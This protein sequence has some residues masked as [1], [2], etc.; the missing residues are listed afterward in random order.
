MYEHSE[1]MPDRHSYRHPK[2][3]EPDRNRGPRMIQVAALV[4]CLVS[5][6]VS[7][8]A[9]KQEPDDAAKGK[10]A[11][12]E[13]SKIFEKP[14]YTAADLTKAEVL[15]REKVPNAEFPGIVDMLKEA[16]SKASASKATDKLDQLDILI[17]LQD[18]VRRIAKT[19]PAPPDL[20]KEVTVKNLSDKRKLYITY[21]NPPK[22]PPS[23]VPPKGELRLAPALAATLQVLQVLQVDNK[24]T[25]KW[26]Q[27]KG[28][29]KP[30]GTLTCNFAE[31]RWNATFAEAPPPA[32]VTIKNAD[33]KRK[34]YIA[35]GDRD[36][37]IEVPPNGES[38]VPADQVDTLHVYNKPEWQ[39]Y[40]GV[41]K[42]ASTLTYAF[43]ENRWK[44]ETPVEPSTPEPVPAKF[45]IRNADKKESLKI[46]FDDHVHTI[47]SGEALSV[48]VSDFV[49]ASVKNG[50]KDEPLPATL[51]IKAGGE[52]AFTFADNRWTPKFSDAPAPAGVTPE[53]T[54]EV[55]LRN[56]DTTQVLKIYFGKS[57]TPLEIPPTKEKRIPLA[58]LDPLLIADGNKKIPVTEKPRADAVISFTFANNVW[59]PKI[60]PSGHTMRTNGSETPSPSYVAETAVLARAWLVALVTAMQEP[61]GEQAPQIPMPPI[62]TAPAADTAPPPAPAAGAPA[63]GGALPQDFSLLDAPKAM[64]DKSQ[65]EL[66]KLFEEGASV[67][68]WDTYVRLFQKP[69]SAVRPSTRASNA[70]QLARL[71]QAAYNIE[72]D[73]T[74]KKFEK[75]RCLYFLQMGFV[76]ATQVVDTRVTTVATAVAKK[77]LTDIKGTLEEL[78]AIR[79]FIESSPDDG[80]GAATSKVDDATVAALRNEVAQLRNELAQLRQGQGTYAPVQYYQVPQYCP[81]TGHFGR[82]FARN[83]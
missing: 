73:K 52:L 4:L 18:F 70:S 65:E 36:K 77:D 41:V 82:L 45:A 8:A 44:V 12:K 67:V 33:D 24:P 78:R 3:A 19:V 10:E 20:A 79:A 51:P 74:L 25:P 75:L 64:V 48:V 42:P 37:T 22:Y 54:Q 49:K 1:L 63:G 66:D 23:E 40:D 15:I 62:P 71:C 27:Y 2:R 46:T 81:P 47:K 76:L 50:D 60:K 68:K 61:A 30:G 28:D 56:E 11:V 29:L 5:A 21:G 39:K 34:L 32:T 58:D 35:Y 80:D 16:V 53:V 7:C 83:R 13:L 14:T 17:P 9:A 69:T 43:V 55:T 72:N 38:Q 59:T 6:S 57:G 26:E 31:N